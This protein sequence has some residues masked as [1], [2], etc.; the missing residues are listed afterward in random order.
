MMGAAGLDANARRQKSGARGKGAAFA[1]IAGIS[2]SPVSWLWRLPFSAASVQ[3]AV[4]VL[5]LGIGFVDVV[6]Q[7]EAANKPLNRSLMSPNG[8]VRARLNGS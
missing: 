7:G 5:G 2:G 3:H 6:R 8:S 4:A 1:H